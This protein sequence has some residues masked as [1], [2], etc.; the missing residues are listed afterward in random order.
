MVQKRNDLELIEALRKPAHIR[1]LAKELKLVPSTVLRTL[2]FLQEENAVD[3]RK[4]GRNSRYFLKPSLECRQYV[5][6]SESYKVLKAI[7]NPLIRRITKELRAQTN[8]ELILLFGSYA[9]GMATAGSDID[10]YIETDSKVLAESLQRI[11]GKISVKIG[12][13]QKDSDLGREILLNHIVLQNLDR[14]FQLYEP[15]SSITQ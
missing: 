13:L 5:E 4:E 9:K 10:I 7:E 14:F 12:K 15:N 11:S 8:G 6:M 2:K 3:F 1:E